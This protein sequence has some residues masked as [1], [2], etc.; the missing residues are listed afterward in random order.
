M[1]TTANTVTQMLTRPS[2]PFAAPK[3]PAEKKHPPI[4]ATIQ[5]KRKPTP[6]SLPMRPGNAGN[7]RAQPNAQR[8]LTGP[9]RLSMARGEK[10][11][12]EEGRENKLSTARRKT[13]HET[14]L[15]PEVGTE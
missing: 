9:H 15:V 1:A 4:T 7:A 2:T 13:T 14:I 6:S 12:H 10:R 11:E 3:I 8:Q 5:A